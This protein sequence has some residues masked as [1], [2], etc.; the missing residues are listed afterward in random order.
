MNRF[1]GFSLV[2]AN[3]F[4][5]LALAQESQESVK[6]QPY[7]GP[8][9]FLDEPEQVAEPTIVSHEKIN[10]K[11]EPTG[12]QRTEREIAR[13]SDNH[14][15]AD[16]VYREYYPNGQLFVEGKFE[17]GRQQGEWTYYFDNGQVNRK[18]MYKD[19]QPDGPREIFRAD[20]TLFAN[21]GFKD[22]RRDGEWVTYDKT[23]KKPLREEHY[24][25]GKADG[26][27][28]TWHSNGQLKQ[29]ISLKG[30]KRHGTS[31]E[32]DEQ[33]VKR[34]EVNYADNKLHGTLTRWFPDGRKVVQ[35]YSEG[36][37]VSQTGG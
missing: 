29:E 16:G 12:K 17:R 2:F 3:M 14:F 18:A 36:R 11:Y 37:L 24:V 1:I 23:G 25:D 20:G 32:W 27:W 22:G 21:R 4:A 7:T 8:P 26:V 9:I 6:I 13:F 34:A 33:G 19:G 31:I 28:K 5:G 35:Q 10:D 30:G 15:E